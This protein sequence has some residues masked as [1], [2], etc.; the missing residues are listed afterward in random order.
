M[1]RTSASLP[2]RALA[3]L[4]VLALGLAGLPL[5]AQTTT[6]TKPPTTTGTAKQATAPKPGTVSTTTKPGTA[7]P[8]KPGTTTKPSGTTTKP[9]TSTTTAKPAASKPAATTPPKPAAPKPAAP[10]PATSAPPKP[11][12]PRT[13]AP[14]PAPPPE[15]APPPAVQTT[16]LREAG[17]VGTTATAA[18]GARTPSFLARHP[19]I[20]GFATG[21]LGASLAESML[22]GAP[23]APPG[24]VAA[25]AHLLEPVSQTSHAAETAGQF[26]RLALFGGLVYLGVA[27]WRRRAQGAAPAAPGLRER[28]LPSVSDWDGTGEDDGPAF[29]GLAH[30]DTLRDIAD[31][32]DFAE[33]LRAVQSAWSE[34]N[35]ALIRAHVTP[36]MADH[37]NDALAQNARNGIESRVERVE[38]V[39]VERLRDWE[40]DGLKFA[41]ARVR[42]K[43]LDYLI[44]T[45]K[46]PDEAG[47]V[48][49]GSPDE[50]VDCEETWTFVKAG[51]GAWVLTEVESAA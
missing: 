11:A 30:P 49:D 19:V 41:T 31:E 46:T 10:K 12:A 5:A 15:S 20:G 36:E 9:T 38:D 29:D 13:E 24:T 6:A 39:R 34:G 18:G 4:S 37:Y 16:P 32:Q 21:L 50:A 33:I 1:A 44:D 42:W 17:P 28:A 7:S 48:I 23:D 2:R 8:A 43:A 26:T 3:A 14:K 47:Y 45:A 35:I 27:A 25:D 51:D 22:G 40:E